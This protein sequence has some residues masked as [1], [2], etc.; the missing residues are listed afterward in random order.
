MLKIMQVSE[1]CED[2]IFMEA[3][4]GTRHW[5]PMINKMTGNTIKITKEQYERDYKGRI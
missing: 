3:I 1:Y 2:Y 4:P 5:K